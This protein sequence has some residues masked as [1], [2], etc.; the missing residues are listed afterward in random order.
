MF[1]YYASIHPVIATITNSSRL[2]WRYIV[3][4]TSH[5]ELAAGSL[6]GL[7][8]PGCHTR[9]SSLIY[10][11]DLSHRQFLLSVKRSH[12]HASVCVGVSVLVRVHCHTCTHTHTHRYIYISMYYYFL[13]VGMLSPSP[14]SP[15]C[16]LKSTNGSFLPTR[17]TQDIRGTY[18]LFSLFIFGLRFPND[19][20]LDAGFKWECVRCP[21]PP[22]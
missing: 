2:P 21:C 4:D 1:I 8:L 10:L 22:Q 17:V 20:F 16:S 14:H 9:L 12:S 19:I 3:I 11:I 18:S 13:H 15:A 7:I 5:S 6:P